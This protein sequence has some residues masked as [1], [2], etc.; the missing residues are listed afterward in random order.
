[1][2]SLQKFIPNIQKHLIGCRNIT[3]NKN[4]CIE[5]VPLRHSFVAAQRKI[6][7]LRLLHT[8]SPVAMSVGPRQ[9]TVTSDSRSSCNCRKFS[10]DLDQTIAKK[11]H[12]V[13]P[14]QRLPDNVRPKHYKLSLVPDLKSFIF[15]GDVSIQIEVGLLSICRY[16]LPQNV[17]SIF[18]KN[19][20][21]FA[22]IFLQLK[23]KVDN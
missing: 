14:F 12:E 18:E 16:L 15:R 9:R 2:F 11:M 20:N 23:L 1:M 8:V 7:R 17:I 6:V 13:K 22:E 5:K 4:W 3:I 10:T 21:F 19:D